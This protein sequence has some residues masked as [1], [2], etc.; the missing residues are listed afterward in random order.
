[1]TR[2]TAAL[3]TLSRRLPGVTAEDFDRLRAREDVLVHEVRMELSDDHW[4]D[5]EAASVRP[6]GHE[7]AGTFAGAL[8]ADDA[9][10]LL[11]VRHGDGDDNR[12]WALPGGHVE[13]GESLRAAAVREAREE[14]GV[15]VDLDRPLSV[16][17]QVFVHP[18]AERT[19]L[20]QFVLYGAWAADP[21]LA[22]DLGIETADEEIAEAA[23]RETVPENA[24][25]REH[26]VADLEHWRSLSARA[27]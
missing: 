18:E 11:F 17:R 14:T 8:V 20:G 10:R 15:A 21:T 22:D 23:W 5:P 25:L 24:F 12:E 13:D 1:V 9:G 16:S 27:P 3:S 2:E 26:V 6:D 19:S 4:A 7:D